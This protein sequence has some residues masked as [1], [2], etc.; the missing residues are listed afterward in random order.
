[1]NPEIVKSKTDFRKYMVGLFVLGLVFGLDI[2]GLSTE[3]YSRLD[4]IFIPPVIAIRNNGIYIRL[5][6]EDL[7]NRPSLTRENLELKRQIAQYEQI[8]A[9]NERLKKQIESLSQ[10]NNI[11]LPKEPSLVAVEVFGIQDL[12]SV[13]PKVRIVVPKNLKLR[14][15]DPVYLDR[16][17][18]L[19]FITE[20][21]GST[22][23]ISPFFSA[24]ISFS[25]PVQSLSNPKIKGFV[26]KNNST[27][28]SIRNIQRDAVVSIGEIFVTTNDVS[29]VPPGLIIGKVRTIKDNIDSG[30]KELTLVPT[31]DFAS[32]TTVYLRDE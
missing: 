3:V 28:I 21:Y 30:F 32:L 31:V 13:N 11:K 15:W 2:L 14:K 8:L 22:A 17:T 25:I 27:E 24:N 26:S 10:E 1:M 6:F 23:V 9:E 20:I 5:A 16:M 18:L 29:E 19:G 7:L 12:Y 4:Q